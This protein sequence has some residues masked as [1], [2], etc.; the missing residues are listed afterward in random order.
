MKITDSDSF[1]AGSRRRRGSAAVEFGLTFLPIMAMIFAVID[2][3]MPIFLQ[4]LFTHAVREGVRYGITYQTKPSM[5][6]SASIKRVVQDCSAGF[7]AES[8][9]LSKIQVKFY[10]PITFAEQTG[11][12]RNAGGNILEVSISGYSWGMMAPLWRSRTSYAV[13]AISSD[14]LE[15]LPFGAALPTP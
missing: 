7:L 3:A 1:K 14:R 4:S 9:N 6:H 8:T 15:H 10:S 12:N 2:F 11:A 13:N 5:T